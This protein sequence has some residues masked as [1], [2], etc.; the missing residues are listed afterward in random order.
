[1]DL[2]IVPGYLPYGCLNALS[3]LFA[4]HRVFP[5]WPGMEILS[6]DAEKVRVEEKR[7]MPELFPADF[8]EKKLHQ[9]LVTQNIVMYNDFCH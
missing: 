5:F 8:L 9:P 7:N 1:L 2:L 3:K 6:P 4:L